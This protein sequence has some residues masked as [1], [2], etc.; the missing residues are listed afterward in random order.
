M[1]TAVQTTMFGLSAY[2]IG[3]LRVYVKSGKDLSRSAV[4]ARYA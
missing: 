4:T 3:P 1:T 2:A